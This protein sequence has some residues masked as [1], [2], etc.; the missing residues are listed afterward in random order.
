MY[1]LLTSWWDRSAGSIVIVKQWDKWRRSWYSS[2]V[3]ECGNTGLGREDLEEHCKHSNSLHQI[4]PLLCFLTL[5]FSP[6]TVFYKCQTNF[7]WWYEVRS[8]ADLSWNI[9]R[10]K[11]P[12]THICW[13]FAGIQCP[14][15]L[16]YMSFKSWSW[17]E[18]ILFKKCLSA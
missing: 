17:S 7:S 13:C 14:L 1:N 10:V 11:T 2:V 4:F 6:V 3:A 15:L 8:L 16:S 18:E 12:I 9:N 5:P